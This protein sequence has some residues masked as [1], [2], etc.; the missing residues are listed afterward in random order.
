[1][2]EKKV[3]EYMLSIYGLFINFAKTTSVESI[4]KMPHISESS[5][6]LQASSLVHLVSSF[7]L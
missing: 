3:Q 1:M 7:A 5:T 6:H 4:L 2:L